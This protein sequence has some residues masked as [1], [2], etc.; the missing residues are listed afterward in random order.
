LPE[1]KNAICVLSGWLPSS[2]VDDLAMILSFFTL[3]LLCNLANLADISFTVSDRTVL[4][5]AA[6]LGI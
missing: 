3:L 5:L 2:E 4:E 1:S 6:I